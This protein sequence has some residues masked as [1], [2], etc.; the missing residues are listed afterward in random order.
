[1]TLPTP[2]A[3]LAEASRERRDIVSGEVMAEE[4]LIRFVAGPGGEVVPDLARKL[5]GRGVW[6]A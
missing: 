1:M 2:A 6:V 5:P 4:R 3:T